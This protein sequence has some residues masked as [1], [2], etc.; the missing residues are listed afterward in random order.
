[1]VSVRVF[2]TAVL[3]FKKNHSFSIRSKMFFFA[4]ILLFFTMFWGPTSARANDIYIA[5]SATGAA[6]GADCADARAVSSLSSTDWKAGNTIHLCRVITSSIT[7]QGSGSSGSPI[8]VYFEAGARI[9]LPYCKTKCVDLTSASYL[10]IDGGVPCGSGTA[11]SSIELSNLTTYATGQ[12]GIIE[13]T[14]AGSPPLANQPGPNQLIASGGT[15]I[16]IRNIILRNGYQHTSFTDNTGGASD[17]SGWGTSSCNGCSIHDSTIHDVSCGITM[18]RMNNLS[19]YNNYIYRVNWGIGGGTN[20]DGTQQVNWAIHDNHF[21][22][23]ANWDDSNNSYHHNRI[24][25]YAGNSAVT[26]PNAF[27]GLYI[28]NNLMDGAMGCCS[29]SHI[30]FDG[31]PFINTYVFNNVET[32]VGNSQGVANAFLEETGGALDAISTWNQA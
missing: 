31:G 17:Y 10:V 22:S 5:Q 3:P 28:Y 24:M 25:L 26:I 2:V 19:I 7:A 1:M 13:A 15:N 18:S 14:A 16:E 23:V 4:P 8:T 11:C 21:G 20:G 27:S 30:F 29:T 6:N 12:A 9:S 32:N